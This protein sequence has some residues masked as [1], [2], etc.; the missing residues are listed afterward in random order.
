MGMLRSSLKV[1]LV[2][3][4]MYALYW[5]TSDRVMNFVNDR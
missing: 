5:G 4:G 2:A 1:G 3:T